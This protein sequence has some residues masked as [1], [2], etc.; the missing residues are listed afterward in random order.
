MSIIEKEGKTVEQAIEKGLKELGLSR[1][2]VQ[3]EIVSLGTSG[4]LGILGARPAKVR[5]KVQAQPRVKKIVEAILARMG[6][7][8]SVHSFNEDG[9]RLTAVIES[10]GGEKY[11]QAN[12]GAALDALEYLLG[13]ICHQSEQDI[14]LDIGGFRQSQG[15]H[16]KTMALEMAKKVKE[17]GQEQKLQPMPPHQRKVI[18]KTLENHPDVKTFAVGEGDRRRVIIAPRHGPSTGSASSLQAGSGQRSG[19]APRH[20]PSTASGQRS[21]QAPRHGSG[22]PPRPASGQALRQGPSTSSG[23]TLRQSPSTS[24]GQRSGQASRQG[25]QR[26]KPQPEPRPKATGKPGRRESS[27]KPQGSKPPRPQGGQEQADRQAPKPAPVETRTDT[28]A[29][30][31]GFVPRSRKKSRRP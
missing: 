30:D 14:H 1:D 2:E 16:L 7:P 13:K 18:H 20:G 24:S 3:V 6:F 26:S 23:Q 27:R 25:G 9:G 4:F 5:L 28:G 22:Q 31:A 17:T 21:G 11:L 29:Q 8:G 15:D 10:D 19:Q 12:N